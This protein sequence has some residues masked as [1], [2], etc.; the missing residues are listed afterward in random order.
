MMDSLREKLLKEEWERE[1]E[2]RRHKE[3]IKKKD[4]QLYQLNRQVLDLMNDK[5]K[6]CDL[7]LNMLACRQP[8]PSYRVFLWKRYYLFQLKVVFE[9][10]SYLGS[11]TRTS[12][13]VLQPVLL[14]I[15]HSC[16]FD[17]QSLLCELFLHNIM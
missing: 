9:N 8:S 10:R 2:A 5:I 15:F 17:D 11:S 4:E 7:F 14:E 12:A 1:W 13:W 3:T 6:L 16:K